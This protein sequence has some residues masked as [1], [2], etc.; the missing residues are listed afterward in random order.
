[1]RTPGV[2]LALLF[3]IAL[4]IGGNVSIHGFIQGLTR[5]IPALASVDRIVSVFGR[6]GHRE[7]GPLSFEEYQSLKSR[8]DVFEWIG[9]ARV[10]PCAIAWA[11]Q[12]EVVSVAAL[13]PK[14]AD[15]LKLP[16]DG[17]VVIGKRMW[18]S[19]FGAKADVRGDQIRIDGVNARISGV[20]PDW[21]E[22]VYRDR[23]VD[24]WMPLQEQAQQGVDRSSRIYWVLGRLRRDVS[25]SQAEAAILPSRTGSGELR[26][27]PYIGM[28][29]EMAGGLSRVGSLL[30]FAAGAVF[31]IACANVAAFL[32]GRA[33]ARSH[34]TSLRVALGA[35]RGQLGEELLSD[36]I[37]VCVVG[38]AAGMLLA[39]WTS[40][41]IPALLFEQDAEFL[42]FAPD[43]ISIA[44]AS[45]VCIGIT[46]VCGLLPV[47]VIPHDRPATVLRR[48]SAGP[49][50]AIRRLR[51]GLV[52]A[53]M[54]SCC[55]L[56]VSTASLLAGLRTALQTSIGHRLGRPILATVQVHPDAGVDIG[57]YEAVE[58]ATQSMAGVSGVVWTAQLPG[59]QPAWQSFRIDPRQLPLREL[60]MDMSWFTA[61][62]P[63]PFILPPRAGRMFGVADRTC[64]VAIVNEEAA[65]ELFDGHPV[66]RVVQDFAGL[67]AGI[68]GVVA[69]RKA[70]PSAKAI[71]PTIY[72]NRVDEAKPAPRRIAHAR[73]RAPIVSEL[74][75]A[76]LAANV[77]SPNYFDAMGF[78][79]IAG[80]R[81][82]NPRPGEC[83]IA[84]INQEAA[85]LY[86][87]GQ[88]AGSAVIDGQGRRTGIVGV[89]HSAP[90]G[91]FQR[92]VEPA[93]YFPM[94]QDAASRMTLIVGA[95]EVNG[96]MLTDL[97]RRIESVPGRGPAPLV[98]KTL[99]TQLG[100]TALAPLRIAGVIV[101]ASATTALVLSVLGLFGALSDAAR[102]RRRELAVRIALGAQRW[103]VICQVLREGAQLAGA[104]TLAG[105]LGSLLLS[106]WLAPITLGNGSL[107]LWVWLAAPILLAGA[108]AIASVLPARRALMVHPLTIMRDDN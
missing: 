20:A 77:V 23:A 42:V 34:E 52:V 31:F 57:Y 95:Q 92:R 60:A 64:R 59:S 78:S 15:L 74:A 69:M 4:G 101:G 106:K 94:S 68:I 40:R 10:S 46:I 82:Y 39:V 85:E 80:E 65:E 70:V 25:A 33:F 6:E 72:Y 32:L 53:Q 88:A 14:L 96:P 47:V 26:V 29:P 43:P 48:E 55:V 86:F 103:R 91:T 81:L 61:D 51:M 71:R 98:V 108:V 97:R 5:P 3:T 93:I 27:L 9:A 73:F 8:L 7:A 21:L 44:A 89:V 36:S 75:G 16:L 38:G 35:S 18:Q 54:A 102:Q 58:R 105:I 1:M 87:G 11:S 30:G 79:P 19:E 17:G 62:S 104:G 28:M 83:R 56:V 41:V 100:E 84:V 63:E 99:E 107:P 49:S 66:G 76:E 13:T 12:S 2:A 24:L 37:V 90:L 50:K 67:P 22:G 45:A